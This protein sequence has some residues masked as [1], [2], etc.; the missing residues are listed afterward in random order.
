MLS[1][2]KRSRNKK[3]REVTEGSEEKG[4]DGEAFPGKS[5]LPCHVSRKDGGVKAKGSRNTIPEHMPQRG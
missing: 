3:P 2:G 5:T 4:E 1:R